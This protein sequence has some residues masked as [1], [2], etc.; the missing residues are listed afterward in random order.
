MGSN[1]SQQHFWTIYVPDLTGEGWRFCIEVFSIYD[2]FRLVLKKVAASFKDLEKNI[3][4]PKHIESAQRVLH[5]MGEPKE[6]RHLTIANNEAVIF[7]LDF[8]LWSW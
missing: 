2:N 3:Y 5:F 6:T 4:I 7:F 1:C 8:T